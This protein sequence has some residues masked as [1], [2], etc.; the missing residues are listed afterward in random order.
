MP[1]HLLVVL[2]L[3]A[4]TTAIAVKWVRIPYSIALVIVG[5]VIGVCHFL[6]TVEMTPHLILLVFLPALLFEA[7]WNIHLKTLRENW[8]PISVLAILGVLISCA[9][10]GAIMH[11]GTGMTIGTA[12]LFGA[13]ISATDPISV[14]ALFRKIG[15]DKRLTMI[16]EGESIFND[17]TGAVLFNLILNIV[18]AQSVFSPVVS[19]ASFL[20]V[21]AGGA[22]VGLILGMAASR[23]TSYF[24]DHLLEITL[25]TILAYGSFLIAEQLKVSPVIA[26]VAAGIVMGNYGSRVGMSATTRLSVN[27]FW[28]Y[29][30]FVVNSLVFL[31]I[32]LQ[33]KFDLLSKY[34]PLIGF[35]ILAILIA[36]IPVVYGLCPLVSRPHAPIP[37]QW[38]HLLYWGALRGSLCMALALSLPREFADREAL[39]ITT[40]GVVLF[41][42]IVKGLTIEPLVKA[43]GMRATDMR[44]REYQALKSSLIAEGEAL[45]ALKALKDAAYI[46]ENT[47]YQ[48]ERDIRAKQHELQN[49]IDNLHLTDKSVQKIETA[50]TK[51]RLLEVRK[52]CIAKLVREG[53]I[54]EEI[55]HH[56]KSEVDAEIYD[57]MHKPNVSSDGMHLDDPT[58][59]ETVPPPPEPSTDHGTQIPE[60]Y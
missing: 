34:A 15:M 22:V 23:V 16:L 39:I 35:G 1:V 49:K 30:A 31:L 51:L 29:A 55:G 27:S 37:W 14:L 11:Y 52:D 56:L 45:A 48:M 36:R 42:L 20:V 21:V 33:V 57:L 54:A 2:L 40:F 50:R 46:A 28:E 18:M 60:P 8:L 58:M 59:I 6:P 10:V 9:I 53:V 25:T 38:Q 4:S 47:Y 41:T 5:L 7:S 44:V 19:I 26:V 17:G 24:D 32:G 13:L 43:L 3:L 12:F